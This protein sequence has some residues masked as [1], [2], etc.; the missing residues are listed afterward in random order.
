MF[1][2]DDDTGVAEKA[3]TAVLTPEVKAAHI[4]WTSMDW[5]QECLM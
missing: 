1:Q 4:N 5:D 3:D 2:Y